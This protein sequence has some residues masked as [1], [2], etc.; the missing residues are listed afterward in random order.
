MHFSKHSN[1]TQSPMSPSCR[2]SSK[3]TAA[4]KQI[5]SSTSRFSIFAVAGEVRP[6]PDRPVSPEPRRRTPPEPARTADPR[7]AIRAHPHA[8]ERGLNCSI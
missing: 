4:P 7:A 6:G 8:N 5:K 1:H 3:H 2:H